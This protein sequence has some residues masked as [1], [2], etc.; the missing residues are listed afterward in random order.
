MEVIPAVDIRLGKCVR[1]TQGKA[2]DETI[3]YQN[4]FEAAL[5]WEQEMGAERIH[6]VDLDGAMG[7]G[8]NS[9]LIAEMTQSVSAKI[10]IGGGIRSIEKAQKFI[11]L[12]ASRVVIG[13]SAVKNPEFIR[14]LSEFLEPEQIIVSLDADHDARIAIKGW[15]EITQKNAFEYGQIFEKLGAGYILY[16]AI[17]NDGTFQD[18]ILKT[19]K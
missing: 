5:F 13:T 18:R 11:E 19:Q 1:L 10:Q 6:F 14:Q 15:T 16:S 17:E 7:T 3:Y 4:P 9:A 2:D 12:G 8:D